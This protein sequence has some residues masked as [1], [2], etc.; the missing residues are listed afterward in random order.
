LGETEWN[1][2]DD[3]GKNKLFKLQKYPKFQI[4]LEVYP[5]KKLDYLAVWL[6]RNINS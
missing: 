5:W 1:P 6:E 2:T 3:I 4:G